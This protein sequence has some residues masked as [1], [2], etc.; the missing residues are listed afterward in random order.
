MA[1]H[2]ITAG[3]IASVAFA[4]RA[5]E[6]MCPEFEIRLSAM[7]LSVIVSSKLILR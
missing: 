7:A 4:V 1:N 3:L 6:D 5:G 2:T